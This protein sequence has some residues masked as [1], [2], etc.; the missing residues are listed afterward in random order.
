M[1]LD[2]VAGVNLELSVRSKNEEVNAAII[3]TI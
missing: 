2:P 3:N 1:A